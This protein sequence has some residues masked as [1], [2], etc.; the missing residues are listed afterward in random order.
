MAIGKN[1]LILKKGKNLKKKKVDAFEKKE[2]FRLKMPNIQGIKISHYGWTPANRTA[3]GVSVSDRLY[4]RVCTLR[5]ADL[6]EKPKADNLNVLSTST[7]IKLRVAK[8]ENNEC[9]LDFHGLELTRDKKCS[10]IRKWVSLIEAS[11]DIKTT[12]GFTFRV[13]ALVLTRKQE[14]QFK[15]TSYAKTSQIKLIRAKMIEIM[16]SCLSENSTKEFV[17]KLIVDKCGILFKKKI[18]PIYPVRD[19]CIRKVK[20]IKRPNK[21]DLRRILELHANKE[22]DDIMDD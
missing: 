12:D 11:T 3:K 5:I 22:N 17:E 16:D 15:K 13:F 4:G 20:L 18:S 9:W 14:Q 10:L 8:I 19:C 6:D 21:E 1:K 7:N 2:W